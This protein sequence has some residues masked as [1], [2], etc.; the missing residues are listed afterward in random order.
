MQLSLV[1]LTSDHCEAL[2]HFKKT[3]TQ[4]LLMD[5]GMMQRTQQDHCEGKQTLWWRLTHAKKGTLAK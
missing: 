4:K 1:A 5:T 2:N 3:Q